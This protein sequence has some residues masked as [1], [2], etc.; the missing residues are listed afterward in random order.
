MRLEIIE[1]EPKGTMEHLLRVNLTHK[2]RTTYSK[3]NTQIGPKAE[4]FFE[5]RS[6]VSFPRSQL[7]SSNSPWVKMVPL[8]VGHFLH[9]EAPDELIAQLKE[10][11]AVPLLPDR[12]F[13]YTPPDA[14]LA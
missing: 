14:T 5:N 10:L 1:A 3:N 8:D 13:K 2:T 11:F 12:E 6:I 7:I 9:L 4:D